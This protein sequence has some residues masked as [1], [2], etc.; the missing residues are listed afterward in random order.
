MGAAAAA[1]A[2]AAHHHGLAWPFLHLQNPFFHPSL[3]PRLPFGTGAFRP[4]TPSEELQNLKSFHPAGGGSSAAF[5]AAGLT[6]P[7]QQKGH[8]HPGGGKIESLPFNLNR[9]NPLFN[10]A[11]ESSMAAAGRLVFNSNGQRVA[12]QGQ[13]ESPSSNNNN[14]SGVA[15]ASPT[16]ADSHP[17]SAASSSHNNNNDGRETAGTPLSDAAT[18]RS[19]P[20]DIRTSR[21]KSTIYLFFICVLRE[22]SPASVISDWLRRFL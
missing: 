1:A 15:A 19:T 12:I 16:M 5:A 11:M 7:H 13:P 22:A 14:N 6:S 21:R 10:S 4:L 2:A 8:H 3:D 9:Y 20:D 17:S 18:E